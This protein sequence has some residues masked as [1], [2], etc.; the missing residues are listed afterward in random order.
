MIDF[1][2]YSIVIVPVIA[3]VV[4][5]LIQRYTNF[6]TFGKSTWII[7]LLALLLTFGVGLYQWGKYMN[8]IYAIN[9]R[10]MAS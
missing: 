9:L 8:E 4:G 3:I 1:R 6:K 7:G 10:R 5:A 2:W